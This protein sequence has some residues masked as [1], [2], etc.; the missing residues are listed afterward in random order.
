MQY[1]KPSQILVSEHDVIVSVIEAVEAVAGKSNDHPFNHGFYEQACD[2]FA[3]FADQCHHAKE[4][5]HLFPLLERRGIPR[6]NGPIGCMLHDHDEGRAH[7][8]AVRE[9]LG[10]AKEG[11]P[12]ARAAVRRE[13]LQ[14]CALLRQHIQKENQVLFVVGDQVM[15]QADKEELLHEFDCAEH[16]SLPPGTHEKYT[17][18]AGELREMAGLEAPA[19]GCSHTHFAGDYVCHAR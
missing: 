18:L 3:T 14:F 9:A 5:A 11:D 13:T 17:S 15:T 10:A 12:S 4:E 7:I 1:S 19:P 2:F 6:Q 16:G 8:R